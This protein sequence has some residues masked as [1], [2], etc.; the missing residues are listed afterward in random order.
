MGPGP[1][2][3]AFG[4]PETSG[5]LGGWHFQKGCSSSWVRGWSVCP[6]VD[7]SANVIC[8]SDSQAGPPLLGAP[9]CTDALCVLA[10]KEVELLLLL[11]LAALETLLPV[12]RAVCVARNREHPDLLSCSV[13]V[14]PV[15]H[16]C[17]AYTTNAALFLL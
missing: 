13:C 4:H 14:V 12:S 5:G 11:G 2:V 15:H 7:A 8:F 9:R 16:F 10:P 1:G 3:V 17:M 6:E